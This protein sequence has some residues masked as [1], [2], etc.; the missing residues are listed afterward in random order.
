MF[1]L[2]IKTIT[3]FVFLTCPS[4]KQFLFYNC[5]D[6]SETSLNAALNRSKTVPDSLSKTIPSHRYIQC[7]CTWY[8]TIFTILITLTL[9]VSKSVYCSYSNIIK[10]A[11]ICRIS[12]VRQEK[13]RGSGEPVPL[14]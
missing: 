12:I 6:P 13:T 8:N 2:S 5:G 3:L 4:D 11:I 14:T 1:V 7:R 9:K 10:S